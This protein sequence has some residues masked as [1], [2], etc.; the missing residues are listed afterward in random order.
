[1]VSDLA[2]AIV[3][4]EPTYLH[5]TGPGPEHGVRNGN[6]RGVA[7]LLQGRTPEDLRRPALDQVR[8]LPSNH[9]IRY[10]N[11]GGRGSARYWLR[12]DFKC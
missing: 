6:D 11:S 2:V 9:V 10:K 1:M 5:A 4:T 3:P 7:A 12:F 8:S